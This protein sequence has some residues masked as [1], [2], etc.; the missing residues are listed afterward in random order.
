MCSVHQAFVQIPIKH[1]YHLLFNCF[2]LFSTVLLFNIV[3]VF[4]RLFDV[5][6][7]QD[8]PKMEFLELECARRELGQVRDELEAVK[9]QADQSA[10]KVQQLTEELSQSSLQSDKHREEWRSRLETAEHKCQLMTSELEQSRILVAQLEGELERHRADA[11]AATTEREVSLQVREEAS[12]EVLQLKTDKQVMAVELETARRR[13]AELTQE[14]NRTR[15]CH[16]ELTKRMAEQ[17]NQIALQRSHMKKQ[18]ADQ[19]KRYTT[20]DFISV[21]FGPPRNDSIWHQRL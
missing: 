16:E 1:S 7:V 10:A 17:Q 18:L 15:N 20:S 21:A 2:R 14:L 13:I 8:A 11:A 4:V 19:R 5:R 6:T 3:L 9:L 12:R